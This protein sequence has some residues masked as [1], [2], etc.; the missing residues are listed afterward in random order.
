MDKYNHLVY[1]GMA[2]TGTPGEATDISGADDAYGSA[3]DDHL[4]PLP[5]GLSS[6]SEDPGLSWIETIDPQTVAH[7]GDIGFYA[8]DWT[9]AV[10]EPVLDLPSVYGGHDVPGNDEFVTFIDD[11]GYPLATIETI[12]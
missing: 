4:I 8:T 7:D 2:L 9:V 6:S 12:F 5:Q 1:F 3:R 11:Y 10:T